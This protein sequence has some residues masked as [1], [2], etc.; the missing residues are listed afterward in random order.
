M[1][2]W[3]LNIYSVAE[4]V[5]C[6]TCILHSVVYFLLKSL[7][8]CCICSL[9]CEELYIILFIVSSL[10]LRLIFKRSWNKVV[11]YSMAGPCRY[12]PANK[13]LYFI[14]ANLFLLNPKKNS[15]RKKNAYSFP[16]LPL[17][18]FDGF[19]FRCLMM[20]GIITCDGGNATI[21]WPW[22]LSVVDIFK[23]VSKGS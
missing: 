14:L 18:G 6:R 1:Y 8:T 10:S 2:C 15:T 19:T 13:T 21:A 4:P 9:K 20:T 17:K 7:K 23:P 5:Y 3:N 12:K 16:W 11:N 22:V